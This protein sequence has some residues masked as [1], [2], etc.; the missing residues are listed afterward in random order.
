MRLMRWAARQWG[1]IRTWWRDDLTERCCEGDTL[2]LTLQAREMVH[3]IDNGESWSVGFYCPCG[4]R[5]VIELLLLPDVDPHWTLAV[6]DHNRP[7]LRP[8]VW[9]IEGCRSHFWIRS[10]R[11]V[12]A[13]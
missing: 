2:P 13:N 12:W 8:S 9:R 4:C 1:R 10:G 11:V 3:M 5:E 6:D 7:T